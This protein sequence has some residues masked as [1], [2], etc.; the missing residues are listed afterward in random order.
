MSALVVER[1][2]RRQRMS[3][4]VTAE[5]LK[6]RTLRAQWVLWIAAAGGG[7]VG[8]AAALLFAEI[9][10][11]TA[12]D[13]P[14]GEISALVHRA[15]TAGAVTVALL[16]GS[17]AIH[18]TAAEH[19]SGRERLTDLEVP[20]RSKTIG[21]RFVVTSGCALVVSLA[22]F[23]AGALLTVAVTGEAIG[24][25]MRQL[26]VIIVTAAAVCLVAV[27]AAGIGLAVRHG[28]TAAVAFATVMLVAPALLGSAALTTRSEVCAQVSAALPAGRLGALVDA[29]AAGDAAR[30]VQAVMAL[31][32]WSAIAIALACLRRPAP[33]GRRGSEAAP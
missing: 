26:S 11:S 16:L 24:G 9:L 28:V 5:F 29:T 21:A 25:L 33:P 8:T 32:A 1:A 7:L 4:V 3:D 17:A 19:S 22:A 27:F 31:A 18:L 12:D 14:A 30:V 15:P 23:G 6:A 10:S 20:A 13:L 2:R